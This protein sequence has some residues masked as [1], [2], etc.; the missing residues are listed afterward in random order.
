MGNMMLFIVGIVILLLGIYLMCFGG[1]KF[2]NWLVFF[3]CLQVLFFDVVMVLFFFVVLVI[4]FYEG[5]YFVGMVC[6]LGV[7][8][9]VFFVWC[10]VL[11]IGVI[12]VVVVVIVLLCLVGMFQ[13][14]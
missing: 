5:V 12:I 13:D 7:V 11:L 10:K 4:I 1:V 9:V 6:V 14:E 8:F 3:E 2:G